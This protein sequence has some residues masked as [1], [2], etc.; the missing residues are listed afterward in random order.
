MSFNNL[1]GSKVDNLFPTAAYT[2]TQNSVDMDL[3][4]V[5]GFAAFILDC[6]ADS[7]SGTTP[8]A[9][10]KIQSGTPA[11]GGT[12]AT[13]GTN[14]IPLRNNTNDNIKLAAK[15]TQSGAR[16]IKYVDLLLKRVGTLAGTDT[17]TLTI[18]GNSTA[19]PDGSAIGTAVVLVP[20]TIGTNYEY[21]RF[22][23][24]NPVTVADA[25]VYW[26]VLAGGY[27]VSTS[28]RICWQTT[29]VASG[30]NANVYDSGWAAV[31]TNSRLF[32]IYQI[33][34]TDF[35][36][37]GFTA[38]TTAANQE[39]LNLNTDKMGQHLRAVFT[40]AGTDSPEYYASLNMV[41]Q[42]KYR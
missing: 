27:D 14:D 1:A 21:V 39:I 36:N 40:L 33:A 11:A 41:Y 26:L 15:W 30:G 42:E 34:F 31:A 29:T 35:T 3:A 24:L 9:T 5:Q 6:A 18:E 19:D 7:G 23:F 20:S 25:T 10:F 32:N 22:T 16:S 8:S 37:G 2:A 13:A 17:L 28:N 38:V 4:G 12:Y